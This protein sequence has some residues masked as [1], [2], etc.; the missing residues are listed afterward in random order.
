[1]TSIRAFSAIIRHKKLPNN[2]REPFFQDANP[3]KLPIDST[4]KMDEAFSKLKDGTFNYTVQTYREH[5]G[6]N[7]FMQGAAATPTLLAQALKKYVLE[8]KLKNINVYHIHTDGPYP[9]LDPDC[10]GHFKSI[11][12][13]TG[14]ACR[15]GIEKGKASYIPIFLSEIPSLFRCGHVPLDLAMVS[16][17]PD[18][19][20]G[21]FSL[22]SS[23]DTT[24]AALQNAKV[25]V[26]QINSKLPYTFGHANV[27]RSQID[28]V[29]RGDM[30]LHLSK[31][32]NV[33][34]VEK[35]I[36]MHIANNLVDDGATLQMGIGSIPDAVLHE[37]SNHKD[38]GIHTEMFTDGLI[39]LFN[40]GAI[41]NTK[42][43]LY[44]GKIVSSFAVGSQKVFDFMHKNPLIEMLDIEYVNSPKVICSMPK[45][46]A[47]NSCI[48]IDLTGQICAD[49]IGT[50]I[51]SDNI[52]TTH[53]SKYPGSGR[54][55]LA[56][57]P[58]P[59]YLEPEL[60][61]QDVVIDTDS[62]V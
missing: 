20:H 6:S 33:T 43:R 15:P 7:V 56:A 28:Y 17:A 5:S 39:D 9:F 30:D 54:F 18:I 53:Q 10:E 61:L 23:I 24:R 25:V 58:P 29:M 55:H 59:G 35:K 46:T 19:G 4:N 1:M 47:I 13:F 2:L 3:S 41:T 37:L 26:G 45:M 51:F 49:S 38:L 40:K 21:Y 16:L 60:S 52:F 12:L 36:A 34:E 8:K 11:S 62:W 42:K 27:H 44:T 31:E 50:R 48:E 22:G 57:L 32:P 14:G